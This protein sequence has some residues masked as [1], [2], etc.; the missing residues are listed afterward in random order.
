MD[1]EKALVRFGLVGVNTSHAGVFARIFN[2]GEGR[3]PALQGARVVAVWGEPEGDAR[4]LV[5]AHDIPALVEDPTE[6]I[7]AVDAVLILDDTGGGA[8]HDRLARPFIE[9]GIPTF[10]DK[11]MALDIDEA[12]ALF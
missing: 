12:A 9:A 4:A 2:G 7:G 3:Q 10:I 8:T 11:P 6:M 1:G 5:A